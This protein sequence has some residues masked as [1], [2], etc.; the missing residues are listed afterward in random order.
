MD[1]DTGVVVGM[2]QYNISVDV[3]DDGWKMRLWVV[4][5]VSRILLDEWDV[6]AIHVPAAF[7]NLCEELS[8]GD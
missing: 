7:L 4:V 5:P 8:Q 3:T 2:G 1:T 6:P